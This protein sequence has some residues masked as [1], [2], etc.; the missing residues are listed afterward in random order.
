MSSGADVDSDGVYYLSVEEFEWRPERCAAAENSTSYGARRE[1]T[2]PG[3]SRVKPEEC[4]LF[5]GAANGAEEA[6][7]AAA[8]RR[9]DGALGVRHHDCYPTIVAG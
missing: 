7:G 9:F 4:V 3:G 2:K 8:E 6:F 1:T 5:S